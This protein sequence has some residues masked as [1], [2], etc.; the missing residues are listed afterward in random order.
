M[1]DRPIVNIS[2]L[3][4]VPTGNGNEFRATVAPIAARLG[5]DKLGYRVVEL[6]PGCKAWPAHLHHVNEEMFF[7][8][9]GA[10]I[11]RYGDETFALSSGDVVGCPAGTAHAH[12]II[13]TSDA[14]LRYLAVSTMLE[15]EVCEY[16]DSGKLAVIVGS[17]PGGDP[18]VR[19]LHS[20]HRTADRVD[21]WL[22]E[23]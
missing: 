5:A 20:M 2:E 3:E 1:S 10:G 19:R 21:Y 18:E 15:P 4:F 11:L 14:P 23:S 22:D 7:V 9:S 13:N 16:P 17:A 6:L 12:Q 8:L